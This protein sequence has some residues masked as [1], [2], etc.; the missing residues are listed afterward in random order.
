MVFHY[1]CGE[2]EFETIFTPNYAINIQDGIY[3]V[4]RYR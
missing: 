4:F 3:E 2:N 1:L